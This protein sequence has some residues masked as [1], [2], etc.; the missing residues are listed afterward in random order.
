MLGLLSDLSDW[1]VA[2]ADTDWAVLALALTSFSESIF[3]PI[4]PDPLLIGIGVLRP[5]AALWLAAMTTVS[6]VAGAVV[7]HWL[8]RRWGRSLLARLVSED[9]IEP[10][11][12]MFKRYGTWAVLMAAFTPVPYKVFAISAGILDLN[13]RSFIVASLVGRGAR[14]LLLGSLLF[15]YG[16]RVEEFVSDYFGI[17]TVATALALAAA[18]GAFALFTRRRKAGKVA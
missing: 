15:V 16:D 3:F 13:L 6:S 8:G 14:F 17:L 12:R 2:F 7:G 4:P 11:E 1:V 5:E 18:L 10:V 9:K